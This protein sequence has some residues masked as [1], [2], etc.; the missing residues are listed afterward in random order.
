[1]CSLIGKHDFKPMEY[2]EFRVEECEDGEEDGVSE[3]DE[4]QDMQIGDCH[5]LYD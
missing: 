2:K 4:E 1:M 5:F 3:D